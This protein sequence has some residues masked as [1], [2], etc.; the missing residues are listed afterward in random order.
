MR[1][2]YHLVYSLVYS[3][4]YSENKKYIHGDLNEK[5]L[6][7]CLYKIAHHRARVRSTVV[8]GIFTPD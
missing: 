4:F 5:S 2:M 8:E 1:A 3:L 7:V 6:N